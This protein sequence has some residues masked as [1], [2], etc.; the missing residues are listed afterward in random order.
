[1]LAMPF[2]LRAAVKEVQDI[3]FLTARAFIGAFRRPYYI[4]DILVQMESIGVGSAP[5]V[6]LTGFFTGAVLTLQ[7]ANTLATIRRRRVK[8]AMPSA[9]R[10]CANSDL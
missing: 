7:S 9:F 10:S 8:R 5:V 1:M 6:M 4:R 3:S 2:S